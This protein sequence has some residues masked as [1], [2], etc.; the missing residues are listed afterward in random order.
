[1]V[2]TYILK[3]SN[4]YKPFILLNIMKCAVTISI[5]EDLV[6]EARKQKINI[7]GTLNS[8]LRSFLKPKKVDLKKENL[9]LDIITFGDGLGLTKEQSVFTHEN[10][11][12]DAPAI[13]KNFKDNF[14]PK[15]SLFDY[16]K[17]RSQ[18]RERFHTNQEDKN[19]DEKP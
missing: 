7:S 4:L 10:L 14:D 5:D 12:L 9:T 15:F 17:I 6:K 16:I 3:Y 13:W 8:M 19:P 18:F 11:E 1:M 2:F